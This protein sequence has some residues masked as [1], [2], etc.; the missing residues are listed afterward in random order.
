MKAKMRSQAW[1]SHDLLAGQGRRRGIPAVV[2]GAWKDFPGAR[3]LHAGIGI[4]GAEGIA[5]QKF[6]ITG[7]T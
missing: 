1:P 5:E 4:S 3:C 7:F 2:S 6:K